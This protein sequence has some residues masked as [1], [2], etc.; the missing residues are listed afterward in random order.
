MACRYQPGTLLGSTTEG[1][2]TRGYTLTSAGTLMILLAVLSFGL[3]TASGEVDWV[4]VITAV[5]GF[6]MAGTGLHLMFRTRRP[7]TAS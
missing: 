6:V 1:E 5:A 4:S 2:N 3:T 7:R